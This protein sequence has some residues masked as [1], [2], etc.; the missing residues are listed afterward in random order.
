MKRVVVIILSLIIIG[1]TFYFGYKKA[2]TLTPK[3]NIVD[4]KILEIPSATGNKKIRFE[5]HVAPLKQDHDFMTRK[6]GGTPQNPEYNVIEGNCAITSLIAKITD[7]PIM[8]ITVEPPLTD[9][10]LDIYLRFPIN[11]SYDTVLNIVGAEL[12][13]TWLSVDSTIAGYQATSNGQ[14]V[15]LAPSRSKTT[16]STLN[17]SYK[18]GILI[19]KFKNEDMVGIL[20]EYRDYFKV[21][22]IDETGITQRFDGELRLYPSIEETK[23]ELS[24]KLGIALNPIEVKIK[25][26][27]LKKR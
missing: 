15:I 23:Q 9:K 7:M 3:S 19:L 2:T 12:G 17:S 14:P 24:T 13:F 10:P 11:E 16:S 1:I 4:T 18:D 22:I 20:G 21:R 25:K 5:Y 27:I 26:L 6:E 8:D